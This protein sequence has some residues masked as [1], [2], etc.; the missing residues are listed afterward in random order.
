MT[1]ETFLIARKLYLIGVSCVLLVACGDQSS[2]LS[3]KGNM[4]GTIGLFTVNG[5]PITD[6]ITGVTVKALSGPFIYEAQTDSAGNYVLTG[7]LTG[8]YSIEVT[9]DGFSTLKLAN[10]VFMG[11][12]EDLLKHFVI[13]ETT[14]AYIQHFS[15]VQNLEEVD[16][17]GSYYYTSPAPHRINIVVFLST[18]SDVSAINYEYASHHVIFDPEESGS[19]FRIPWLSGIFPSGSRISSPIPSA[20]ASGS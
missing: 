15:L 17:E 11:G 13:A 7:L 5:E 12:N 1:R 20:A 14:S 4:R 2:E 18:G 19:T 3:L 16:G 10:I 9:K 8:N 6:A